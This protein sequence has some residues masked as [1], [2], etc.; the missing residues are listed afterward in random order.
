MEGK[1]KDGV[2]KMKD[3]V[4]KMK[5]VGG[6][7]MMARKIQDTGKSTIG[8]KEYE[9][10]G[11]KTRWWGKNKM[12]GK[13]RDGGEKQD[14]GEKPRWRGKQRWRGKHKM[15]GKNQDGEGNKIAGKM[16]DGERKIHDGREK[17]RYKLLVKVNIECDPTS[18][19]R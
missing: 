16:E 3:S 17:Q 19:Q 14:G 1:T 11:E 6:K 18:K 9:M 15:A 13:E 2:R 8:R 5:H 10:A 7:G 12:A 4:R